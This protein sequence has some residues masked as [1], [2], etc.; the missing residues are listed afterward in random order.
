MS[1][2]KK[3]LAGAIVGLLFS[4]G[5]SA[6]TLG[7][8]PVSYAAEMNVPVNLT[9]VP[10]GADIDFALGYN[11]SSGEFRAARFE[12]TS[13]VQITTINSI[14]LNT[15]N[16]TFGAI[17]G[18]GTQAISFSMTAVNPLAAATNADI[19]TIDV[20][21]LKLVGAGDVNCAF[22]LYDQPSQAAN[23]GNTGLIYTTGM[24]AYIK[25]A[26]SFVFAGTPGVATA[27]VEAANGAYTDFLGT[28]VFGSLKFVPAAAMPFKA[29]G[30][31]ITMA[32]IFSADTTV[33]VDGDFSAADDVDWDGSLEDDIDDTMVSYDYAT[34]AGLDGDLTFLENGT[35]AI[36][37]SEYTATL[38]ADTN[39]GYT[40]NNVTVSAGKIVRNGTE[41]QAP[42]VQLPNGYL[43]RIALTNTGSIARPYKMSVITETGTTGNFSNSTGT[44]P[45]NGMVVV[46]LPNVLTYVGQSRGAVTVNVSGPT[47]QIQGLYQIV[48]PAVGS[49]SNHVMVRPG[50][51]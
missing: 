40:V 36:P 1:L 38:H 41:L 17:N 8:A 32:D 25:R 9:P 33:S 29:D 48:N 3:L 15:G 11:F 30:T 27:D 4:T 7:T 13:N 49:I 2:N 23:G 35:D 22:S 34:A 37:A 12:C 18:T 20:G 39:A 28:D 6:A 46:D 43:S 14:T 21:A 10:A 16:V 47:N 42:L 45:A 19:V 51:N 31:A 44:I 5:A 50:T 26:P 24:K